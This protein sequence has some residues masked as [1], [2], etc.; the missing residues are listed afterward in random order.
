[1]AK[2]D[3]IDMTTGKK[4]EP[5]PVTAPLGA[6]L[7]SATVTAK[8][9]MKEV[10]GEDI[11]KYWRSL[12]VTTQTVEVVK[13]GGLVAKYEPKSTQYGESIRLQG[14]F[15][16]TNMQSGKQYASNRCYLPD[17]CTDTIVALLSQRDNPSE[18]VKFGV[19]VS[20]NRDDKSTTGYVYG[21]RPLIEPKKSNAM[22][23]IERL[24]A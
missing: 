14:D 1:M 21:F 19:V 13:V 10:M 17:I 7:G 16:A 18:A 5:E 11:R 4:T 3:A 15:R 6:P 24:L 2:G 8:I 23:E 12:P 22:L 20:L 9:T